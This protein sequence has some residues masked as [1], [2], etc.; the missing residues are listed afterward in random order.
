[1]AD[2]W[3]QTRPNPSKKRPSPSPSPQILQ[4]STGSSSNFTNVTAQKMT[5]KEVTAS[6]KLI[7]EGPAEMWNTLKVKKS[8]FVEGDVEVKGKMKF[9]TYTLECADKTNDEKPRTCAL[10]NYN[11]CWVIDGQDECSGLG[12][13]T[14]GNWKVTAKADPRHMRYGGECTILCF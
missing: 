3:A 1:M 4:P 2:S 7:S 12:K 10:G 5:A 11:V 6:S 9:P 14:Q 13:D 8:L